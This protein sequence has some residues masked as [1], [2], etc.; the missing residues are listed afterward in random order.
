MKK[1]RFDF[2]IVSLVFF[3]FL[4]GVIQFLLNQN[5]TK[6]YFLLTNS[7]FKEKNQSVEYLAN[8][9]NPKVIKRILGVRLLAADLVWIDMLIKSDIKREGSFSPMYKAS[10]VCFELDSDNFF[11]Y[12]ALGLYLS[13]IK[14]DIKGASDILQEGARLVS[15]RLDKRD[16]FLS[17]QFYF[18]AWNIYFAYAYHLMFEEQEFNEAAF[19]MQKLLSFKDGIPEHVINLAKRMQTEKGRLEVGLRVL[20]D[21]YRRAQ[22]EKQKELVKNKMLEMTAEME[23]LELQE[24]FEEYLRLT[25]ASEF[26]RKKAFILFLKHINHSGKDLLG[27]K[28]YLNDLNKV[29]IKKSL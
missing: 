23:K 3:I 19:W 29:D 15:E 27:R 21:V 25:K 10:K 17:K 18:Y 16:I 14:D 22:T 12:Y 2:S 13:V 28:F 4:F 8:K 24:K 20:N 5:L 6:R 26:N 9:L 7:F 1:I 11:A